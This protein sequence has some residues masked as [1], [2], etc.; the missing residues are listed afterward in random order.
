[1]KHL[2][3]KTTN[4]AVIIILTCS[5]FISLITKAQSFD[6]TFTA[7]VLVNTTTSLPTLPFTALGL[8]APNIDQPQNGTAA[9]NASGEE[10]DYTPNQNYIGPDTFSVGFCFGATDCYTINYYIDVVAYLPAVINDDN[11]STAENTLVTVDVLANDQGAMLSVSSVTSPTSGS[12]VLN[13]DQTITYTPNAGYNGQDQFS[14]TA[15]DSAGDCSS[16]T[17]NIQVGIQQQFFT[18]GA[19]QVESGV[20]VPI[21]LLELAAVGVLPGGATLSRLPYNGTATLVNDTLTYTSNTGFVGTDTVHTSFPTAGLVAVW[22]F[23]VVPVGSII[24]IRSDF[25]TLTDFNTTTIDVLNNDVGASLTISNF[26]QTSNGSLTFD[27]NTQIFTYTPDTTGGYNGDSFVYTAC[28][29]LGDCED[30][31][32]SISSAVAPPPSS[33]NFALEITTA[34]NM[35]ISLFV[36]GLNDLGYGTIV[37]ENATNGNA[38][39]TTGPSSFIVNGDTMTV[40]DLT[41]YTPDSFYVGVDSF[42]IMITDSSL[43]A[44]LGLGELSILVNVVDTTGFQPRLIGVN[45]GDGSFEEMT[46]GGGFLAGSID[47]VQGVIKN[48]YPQ[49]ASNLLIVEIENIEAEV[50]TLRL[51]D[52]QGKEVLNVQ[53]SDATEPIRMNT[54][55]L[56]TGY[57]LLKVTTLQT[58]LSGK[59]LIAR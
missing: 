14:Y 41:T 25:I 44:A 21:P 47:E 15:C 6:S 34:M 45:S 4:W 40:F 59:V 19:L 53:S 39:T 58:A 24:E 55:D 18:L 35:P 30:G 1:M 16:A 48:I 51:F 9:F 36:Q 22:I 13:P 52:L 8:P 7:A 56:L 32:V 37:T 50:I 49:P 28:N 57:Y 20:S 38:T 33:Q 54:N 31:V 46:T 5:T 23:D 29:V 42:K 43:G 11:T 12:A 2:L 3:K 26:T 27:N 10:V 17:V